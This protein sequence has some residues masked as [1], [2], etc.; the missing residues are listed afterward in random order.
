M[1]R[2]EKKG[3][4]VEIKHEATGFMR[5]LLTYTD[6]VTL[7]LAMFIVMYATSKVDKAKFERVMEALGAQ[8][9]G[10]QTSGIT[11][12]GE[13]ILSASKLIPPIVPSFMPSLKELTPKEQKVKEELEK[14]VEKAG[15]AGKVRIDV[16]ERG[17]RISLLTDN[18]LFELGKA[19]LKPQ[20]KIILNAIASQI[21]Q[22]DNHIRIEGH[23][24]P[25]PIST[26]EFPS[27]WELSTRRATNVLRYLIEVNKISPYRISAAGYSYTRPL[28][29]NDSEEHRKRNRRVDIVVLKSK[30]SSLE[31]KITIK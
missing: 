30:E 10:A 13:G 7:L 26:S 12:R 21:K 22:I 11:E 19:D 15:I 9:G 5:W 28:V 14:F 18:A 31:P 4:G 24:C 1:P 27:N 16:E 8:L 3:T 23:T 6:M 25:L 20:T 17:I 2:R 29:K